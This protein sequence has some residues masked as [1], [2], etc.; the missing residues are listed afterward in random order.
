MAAKTKKPIIA[1]DIDDVLSASAAGFVAY[2]NTKWGTN[3]G[4]DDYDE[5]WVK[6]W[7][8]DH[9]TGKARA[10]EYYNAGV[11]SRYENFDE[12]LPVLTKL[13][14]D[15]GLVIATSRVIH[16]KEDTLEW[17]DRHYNGVFSAVHL[18]GIYDDLHEDAILR[19][20]ADLC[21]SIG[22]QYLIDDQPKH[23]IAVAEIGIKG[24]LFGDYSWNRQVTLKPGMARV[25]SW[26]EV[27]KY[28]DGQAS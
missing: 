8:V 9:A 12:A 11:V 1:V 27:E 14:K 17:L 6:L 20:K 22:A 25:R 16:V 10:H 18:A 4:I 2:T 13:S 7:E 28:F 21:K 24:L 23:C 26:Q 19:T 3:L 15:Y 5:D